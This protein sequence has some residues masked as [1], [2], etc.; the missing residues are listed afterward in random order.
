MVEVT[1]SIRNK[2]Q[3]ALPEIGSFGLIQDLVKDYTGL[4]KQ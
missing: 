2:Q 4:S 3:L 1:G